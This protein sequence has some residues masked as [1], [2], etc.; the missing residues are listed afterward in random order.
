MV[1]SKL[2]SFFSFFLSDHYEN[3]EALMKNVA[4]GIDAISVTRLREPIKLSFNDTS[5][6][7]VLAYSLSNYCRF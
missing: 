3:K 5:C 6:G 2:R 4:R 7:E 1:F